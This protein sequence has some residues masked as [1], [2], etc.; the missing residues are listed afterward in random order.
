MLLE[1]SGKGE[2]RLRIDEIRRQRDI[3]VRRIEKKKNVQDG[4][5]GEKEG[6]SVF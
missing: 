1:E 5:R 6:A 3:K 4:R 2:R